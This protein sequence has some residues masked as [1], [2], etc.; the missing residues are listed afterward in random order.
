MAVRNLGA[1]TVSDWTLVF[2][3]PDGFTPCNGSVSLSGGMYTFI[4]PS[5]SL[6]I[7]PGA[8]FQTGFGGTCPG[9]AWNP[10]IVAI[11]NGIAVGVTAVDLVGGA[12]VVTFPDFETANKPVNQIS[13]PQ[14]ASQ[15]RMSLMCRE[16]SGR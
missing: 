16:S 14:G 15:V 7:A 12:P 11:F 1:T 10:P 13:L 2:A 8:T 9:T 3:T 6:S 5:Y 4:P